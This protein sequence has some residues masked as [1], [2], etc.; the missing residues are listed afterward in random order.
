[1][2][3][4]FGGFCTHTGTHIHT[5]Q[6]TGTHRHTQAHTGTH[7]HTVLHTCTQYYTQ[8]HRAK[9]VNGMYEWTCFI[10]AG[11]YVANLE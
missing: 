2:C 5:V 11:R 6:H 8:A 1:M 9:L 4:R 10:I 3:G 7:R